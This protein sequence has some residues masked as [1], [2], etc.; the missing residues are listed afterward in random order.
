[1]IYKFYWGSS[2][3]ESF[4]MEILAP[5]REVKKT[6]QKYRKTDPNYNR[7]DFEK[8]LKKQGIECKIIEPIEIY[9]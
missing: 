5:I 9:F 3:E 8:F 1:M 7:D 6:L 2:A 4:L